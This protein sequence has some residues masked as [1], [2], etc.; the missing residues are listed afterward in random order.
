VVADNPD[1]PTIVYGVK[2]KHA[3]F[4]VVSYAAADAVANLTID[5]AALGLNGAY[6]VTDVETGAEIPVNGNKLSFPLKRHDV[7]ECRVEASP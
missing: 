1:L 6:R 7:R 3:V 2:G 4:T 5:P